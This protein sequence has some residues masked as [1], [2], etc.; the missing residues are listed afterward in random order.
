MKKKTIWTMEMIQMSFRFWKKRKIRHEFDDIDREIAG[1]KTA[2]KL[3]EIKQMRRELKGHDQRASSV[4][5]T[6]SSI[7]QLRDDL[8]DIKEIAEELGL[9]KEGDQDGG[10]AE[11]VMKYILEKKDQRDIPQDIVVAMD[12]TTTG[13]GGVGQ[14]RNLPGKPRKSRP[15]DAVDAIIENLTPAQKAMILKSPERLRHVYAKKLSN[16][17]Y[18]RLKSSKAK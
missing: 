3:A 1:L 5:N 9:N 8:G 16:D 18:K 6:R 12:K 2:L 15:E 11:L 13:S 7:K 17:I 10:I 14:D 4:G